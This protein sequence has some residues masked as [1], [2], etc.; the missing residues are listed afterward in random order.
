MTALACVRWFLWTYGSDTG[1]FAQVIDNVPRGF[2]DALETGGTHFR[3]HWS[4]ILAVLWPLVAITRSP[5]SIQIAQVV[6]ISLCAFP[7]YAIVSEYAGEAWGL[8]CAILALLYPPL[9]ANAFAEFHE[10]AFYPILALTLVWAAQRKR[11]LWFALCALAVVL[12]REDACLDLAII[13]VALGV[14]ALF[15]RSGSLAVAWF[16][17]AALST[18]SLAFYIFIV[19]P[20]TG[21]WTPSHFYD[22]PFAHGPL[23]T[24]LSI[25]THPVALV[26]ATATRGRLTYILEAFVPLALLPLLTRWTWLALPAFAGIL[27]SSDASVWRMGMHYVLLWAP[28][29]ILAAAFALIFLARKSERAAIAWWRTAIAICIIFLIAFN[30]MHPA[31]YLRAEPYQHTPDAFRAFACVPKNAAVGTHDEWFAHEALAYPRATVIP[32]HPQSFHG[33]LVYAT[34]WENAHFATLLPQITAATSSG[35]IRIVCAYGAVRVGS[36]S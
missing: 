17:L 34:D 15:R 18:A 4:P 6:L 7:V 36:S 20:R 24:A 32:D 3:T 16:S 22:Y 13:G 9:L 33:Y 8:R 27:L 35:K 21:S 2:T 30:P 1:T 26:Q 14:S 29:M 23:Q 31:H 19:L 5:L 25:F 28:W 12:V 10:L 11:W